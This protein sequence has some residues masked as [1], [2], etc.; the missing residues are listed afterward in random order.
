M[1]KFVLSAHA[2]T[3]INERSIDLAWLERVLTSPERVESG[4]GH[5]ELRHALGRIPEHGNR[6]LRVIYND[7]V[8]PVRIV[9][10]YFDRKLRDKL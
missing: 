4:K 3:V 5:P 7:A 6:V 1:E 8:D 10:V 2:Q 9:I